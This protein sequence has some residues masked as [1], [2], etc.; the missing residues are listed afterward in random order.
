MKYYFLGLIVFC[1]VIWA[2][3]HRE[4]VAAD[5]YFDKAPYIS[6]RIIDDLCNRA[7]AIDLNGSI[8]TNRYFGTIQAEESQV[9]IE[10]VDWYPLPHVW[11]EYIGK[12]DDGIYALKRGRDQDRGILLVEYQNGL[13]CDKNPTLVLKKLCEIPLEANW[14]GNAHLEGRTL[15][16]G[17]LGTLQIENPYSRQIRALFHRLVDQKQPPPV[18]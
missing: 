4:P 10:P 9:S 3:F 12:T 16:L 2:F 18:F 11:Y 8:G 7:V 14:D 1:L 5:Y 15:S 6:P 13:N 17:N